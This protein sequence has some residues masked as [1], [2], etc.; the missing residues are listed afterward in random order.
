MAA[1][2]I[3]S[4]YPLQALVYC[5]ALHRFLRARLPGYR[6]EENVAGVGYLFVRGMADPGDAEPTGVFAWHPGPDLIAAAS[7]LLGGAR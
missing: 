7:E 1:E 6:L 5:V 4:H 3:R 2:M